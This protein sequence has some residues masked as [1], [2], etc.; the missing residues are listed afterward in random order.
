A[1]KHDLWFH[2]R[3]VPG[4]HVVLRRPGPTSQP[5]RHAL[6]TVA[7]IAAHYSGARHAGLAPVQYTE[8]KY[9][10]KPRGVP[11]GAVRLLREDVLLVEP[12]LP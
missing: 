5:S 4:S 6:E 10:V 9:V 3:D 12:R 1:Q 8:R 7:S 2:A 11:A